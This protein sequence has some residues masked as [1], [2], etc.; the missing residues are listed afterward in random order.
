MSG[1]K[2]FGVRKGSPFPPAV[3]T[4]CGLESSR[5]YYEAA[6]K[7]HI[8]LE[9]EERGLQDY[10]Q[11]SSQSNAQGSNPSKSAGSP[12]TRGWCLEQRTAQVSDSMRNIASN[13][14][15]SIGSSAHFM[16]VCVNLDMKELTIVVP[17]YRE[18][19]KK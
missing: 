11:V 2:R 13:P 9:A 12:E 1:G 17:A 15:A 8:T 6:D 14:H 19:Q 7:A 10:F 4:I 18:R 16:F 5:S 3:Q